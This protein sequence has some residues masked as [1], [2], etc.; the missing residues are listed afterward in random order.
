MSKPKV[1]LYEPIHEE[2]MKVLQ[3]YAQ[4]YLASGCDEETIVREVAPAQGIIIRAVGSVTARIM[5]AA[6]QLRVIGRH[7]VGVDNVDIDAATERGIWVVNTPEAVTEP[8]AEHV[9]G[10]MV[11][12]VKDFLRCDRAVR[13]GNWA[14]RETVAGFNL[15][16]KTLGVV[17]MGRIG[18][19]TAEIA[20]RGLGM[21]ILYYDIQPNARAEKELL[22]RRC[23]LEEVLQQSDIVTLHTPY[24]PSTHHLIDGE[25]LRL[26]KKSAYLINAAR[27]KV[28]DERALVRALQEGWIAGAALDVFEQE[29]PDPDNPLLKLDNVLLTPHVASSTI[30][31]L[32]GMALV[33]EDIVR[34]LR[35]EEP[36]NPVNRPRKPRQQ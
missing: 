36:R 1:L 13:C 9:I 5:D 35:G 25:R 31:A 3:Q 6:P 14:Y 2:G 18:Y 24:L 23:T 29:P 34:V 16:G 7:G 4:P 30:E 12:I 32:I 27:G 17:G 33:A 26:M 8:V 10:M 15:R 22:A 19:R 28:I 21:N 20:H 11:A